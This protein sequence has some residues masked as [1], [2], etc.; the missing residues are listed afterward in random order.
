MNIEMQLIGALQQLSEQNTRQV[1]SLTDLFQVQVRTLSAQHSAQASSLSEQLLRCETQQLQQGLTLQQ[2][3][4]QLQGLTE[5][6]AAL[7][8][9]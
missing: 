9:D 4:R 8:Q 2:L 6:L 1:T 3:N 7:S 5:Q